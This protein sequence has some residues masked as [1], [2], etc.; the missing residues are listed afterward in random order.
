MRNVTRVC[1]T[2]ALGRAY[3]NTSSARDGISDSRSLGRSLGNSL[4]SSLGNSDGSSLGSSVG[5]LSDGLGEPL[6]LALLSVGDFLSGES[7]SLPEA[8]STT[9]ATAAATTI[10]TSSTKS[11]LRRLRGPSGGSDGVQPP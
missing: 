6:G 8:I 11:G 4:G 1:R 2:S 10:T 7:S 9:T 3:C 5:M